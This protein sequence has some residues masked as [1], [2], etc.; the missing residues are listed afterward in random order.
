VVSWLHWL[1]L[2]EP[3]HRCGAGVTH[4]PDLFRIHDEQCCPE[5]YA[6]LKDVD[7]RRA[8]EERARERVRYASSQRLG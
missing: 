7:D 6:R 5:C 3:C 4:R 2:G 8:E 1:G